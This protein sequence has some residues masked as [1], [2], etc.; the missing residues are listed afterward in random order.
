[1]KAAASAAENDVRMARQ[2]SA[3]GKRVGKGE[4]SPFCEGE[5]VNNHLCLDSWK[6]DR[7]N[8]QGSP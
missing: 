4:H 3:L 5:G 2:A 8:H 6:E 7:P 1:M